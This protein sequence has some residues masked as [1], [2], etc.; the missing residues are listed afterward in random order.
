MVNLVSV[1][2]ITPIFSPRL[3][4]LSPPFSTL[5]LSV[6]IKLVGLV[7]GF[8]RVFDSPLTFI[9]CLSVGFDTSSC[10][11]TSL[12]TFVPFNVFGEKNR[13]SILFVL[14]SPV[15]LISIL[16]ALVINLVSGEVELMIINYVFRYFSGI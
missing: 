6:R 9:G 11:V 8:S 15:S 4:V 5:S 14:S 7:C 2:L 13:F 16:Y 1:L 3:F 12:F 10:L